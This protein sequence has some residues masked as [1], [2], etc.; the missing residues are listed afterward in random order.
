MCVCVCEARL[1]FTRYHLTEHIP[2]MFTAEYE[3]INVTYQFRGRDNVSLF[4]SHSNWT[5]AIMIFGERP[6]MA[7]CRRAAQQTSD[8]RHKSNPLAAPAA[9]ELMETSRRGS[10]TTHWIRNDT[11][12]HGHRQPAS[13][14]LAAD[15]SP[16][17]FSEYKV[18]FGCFCYS[19]NGQR[20]SHSSGRRYMLR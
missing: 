7:P 6:Q 14:Q 15:A 20:E 18:H 11:K 2:A 3:L 5:G 10:A 1:W 17:I 16:L 19:Y 12:W 9:H 4:D 13:R 8:V